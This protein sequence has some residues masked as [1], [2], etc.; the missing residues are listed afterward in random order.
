MKLVDRHEESEVLGN[1]REYKSV[2]SVREKLKLTVIRK[3]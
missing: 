1:G 2:D 3:E